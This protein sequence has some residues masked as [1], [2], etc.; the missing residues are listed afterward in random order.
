MEIVKVEPTPS[1]NTMK[2]V[3]SETREDR[4]SSTYT[5]VKEGQPPFINAILK[6]EEVKSVF[7]C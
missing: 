6:I 3:L 1:P 5:E 2:I 7:M 4:H